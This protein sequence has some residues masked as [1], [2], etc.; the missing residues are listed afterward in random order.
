MNK[1]IFN[2]VGEFDEKFYPAYYEDSDYI[3]RLKLLGLRQDVD[4]RLNPKDAR[5]SQTYEKCPEYVNDAMRYNR[6]R[7]I[8]KWGDIPLLEKF[9]TPFNN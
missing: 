5:V 4:T 7:Y 2:N 3:Y 1:D 9:I 6:Q 8:D